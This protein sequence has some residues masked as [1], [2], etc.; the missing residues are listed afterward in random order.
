MTKREAAI[1][2]AYTGVLVGG[3]DNLHKYIESLFNRPVFVR[4]LPTLAELQKKVEH[5]YG[6]SVADLIKEKSR[7]DFMALKIEE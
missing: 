4:E 5:I 7:S 6:E 1:I 3:F 2:S